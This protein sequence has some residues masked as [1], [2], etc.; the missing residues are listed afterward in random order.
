MLYSGLYGNSTSQE[1][2][3]MKKYTNKIGRDNHFPLYKSLHLLFL[4]IAIYHVHVDDDSLVLSLTERNSCYPPIASYYYGSYLYFVELLIIIVLL[5]IAIVKYK[6]L[7][8]IS[9]SYFF[10]KRTML[11]SSQRK[12]TGFA[13]SPRHSTSQRTR[14]GEPRQRGMALQEGKDSPQLEAEVVR[15]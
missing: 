14:G 10:S 13:T 6:R 1:M 15:P 4:I 5:Y 11:L 3:R 7:T 8:K 9:S 12:V 2:V